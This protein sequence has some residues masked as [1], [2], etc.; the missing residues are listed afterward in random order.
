MYRV[1]T[2][3]WSF[4]LYA[5]THNIH[6]THAHPLAWTHSLTSHRQTV[7]GRFPQEHNRGSTQSASQNYSHHNC[8][9]QRCQPHHER[10]KLLQ[11]L[12]AFCKVK[13]TP[14]HSSKPLFKSTTQ[15]TCCKFPAAC[16]HSSE[17]HSIIIQ[18]LP[19]AYTHKINVKYIS[20]ELISSH[21]PVRFKAP[22]M[23]NDN[24]NCMNKQ[25]ALVIAQISNISKVHKLITLRFFHSTSLIHTFSLI[26][27]EC[28][29]LQS[30]RTTKKV[31]IQLPMS[32]RR[33]KKL[34]EKIE[35]KKGV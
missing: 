4:I 29:H 20:I 26:N 9:Y 23:L 30:M 3:S 18:V 31:G 19:T 17:P 32:L 34:R 21:L 1:Y 16:I 2:T 10:D 6:I 24:N 25:A 13:P 5:C 22:N 7:S 35:E 28:K 14:I 27:R 8:H 15:H 12:S 33:V 11:L